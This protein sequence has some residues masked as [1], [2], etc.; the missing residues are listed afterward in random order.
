MGT[1]YTGRMTL[2]EKLAEIETVHAA[3]RVVNDRGDALADYGNTGPGMPTVP[4]A[5]REQGIADCKALALALHAMVR[6]MQRECDAMDVRA[7]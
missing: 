6:Q 1:Q 5:E 2:E 4:A 3:L 7:T